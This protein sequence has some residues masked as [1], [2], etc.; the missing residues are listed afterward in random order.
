MQQCR[1]SASP[2]MS[3]HL[4]MNDLS[5]RRTISDSALSRGRSTSYARLNTVNMV[6]NRSGGAAVKR[7]IQTMLQK[8]AE[9]Q[10]QQEDEGQASVAVDPPEEECC[11]LAQCSIDS[12]YKVVITGRQ[13]I[14]ALVETMRAFPD[15]RGLQECCCLTLGNLGAG[16]EG[17]SKADAIDE[18]GGIKLIIAAMKNHPNSVAVQSAACEALRNLGGAVLAKKEDGDADAMDVDVEDDVRTQ[19]LDVLSKAKTMCMLP[20]HRNLADSLLRDIMAPPTIGAA[21]G[22]AR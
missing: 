15:H 1:A 18:A 21:A 8:S 11:V 13:G 4:G 2:S 6:M 3:M 9:K 19:L 20:R 16:V 7:M 5:A 12:Y 17:N 14:P 10:R 22:V